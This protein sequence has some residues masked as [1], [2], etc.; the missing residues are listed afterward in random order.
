MASRDENRFAPALRELGGARPLA[1]IVEAAHPHGRHAI[2]GA[3][4]LNAAGRQSIGDLGLEQDV[5]SGL[6]THPRRRR[7]GGDDLC[8][9]I[10]GDGVRSSAS[11]C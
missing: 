6:E 9:E 5:R 8:G 10:R 3:D 7:N 11:G 1:K 2:G 4:D